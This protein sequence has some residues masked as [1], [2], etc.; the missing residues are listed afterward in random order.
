MGGLGNRSVRA[1]S[2]HRGGEDLREVENHD[3]EGDD[4]AVFPNEK[5]EDLQL[6]PTRLQICS[7]NLQ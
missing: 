7:D 4:V 1:A 3:H 5:A 2:P 6:I